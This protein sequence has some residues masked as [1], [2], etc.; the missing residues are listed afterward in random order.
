MKSAEEILRAISSLCPKF[1]DPTCFGCIC[2]A[3]L[4]AVRA[5]QIDAAEWM[6]EEAAKVAETGKGWGKMFRLTPAPCTD[7]AA[8]AI[9]SIK[10][11]GDGE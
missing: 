3:D 2:D 5:A 7:A 4:A 6:R 11:P 1:P 10:L 9:R 8:K